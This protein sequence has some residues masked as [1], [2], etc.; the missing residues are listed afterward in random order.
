MKRILI[1]G[2]T[3]FIG[4]RLAKK[5]KNRNYRVLVIGRKIGEKIDGVEYLK[6]D[7]VNDRIPN[8]IFENLN[9][10]I[11]LAGKNIFGRWNE[12]FKKEI[13]NSRIQSTRNLIDT[14]SRLRLKPEFLISASATG[15]YGDRGEDKIHE[16]SPPGEDF[17][18]ELCIDWEKE[19]N[20][21]R[22]IGL[23][24]VQLRTAPVLDR[25][26]GFLSKI[27]PLFRLG[28]GGYFGD[29]NWWMPWI[30]MDDLVNI[31]IFSVEKGSLNG[32]I[33][34]VSPHLITNRIFSKILAKILK[35][36]I[37]IRYPKSILKI[38][39]GEVIDYMTVSQKVIPEK[40]L[41]NKFEFSFEN[42]EKAL[43]NLLR[44]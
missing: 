28:L 5:L 27:L 37:F 14:I 42:L 25:D 2:G 4:R 18:S 36:P 43:V 13:Y 10:I 20:K 17:L 39:L 44:Q 12:N 3:G 15:Y 38:I 33:N 34:A 6:A 9:G 35:R 32:P 21:A 11:H 22:E 16:N 24:V 30:H 29:G 1:T 41:E 31:Y 40:L 19:V 26:G 8:E 7:L 23:R